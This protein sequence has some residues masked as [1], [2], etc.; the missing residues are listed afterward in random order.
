MLAVE[1]VR[2]RGLLSLLSIFSIFHD[3]RDAIN[4]R[5]INLV[6]WRG[7]IRSFKTGE[8]NRAIIFSAHSDDGFS[9]ENSRRAFLSETRKLSA[10]RYEYLTLKND[11]PPDGNRP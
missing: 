3:E 2:A 11:S 6:A 5:R 10:D 7:R 1:R 4:N 9:R 8:G